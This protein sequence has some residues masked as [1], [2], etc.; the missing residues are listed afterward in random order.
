MAQP[1][2]YGFNEFFTKSPIDSVL[3]AI[4]LIWR[5]FY[6]DEYRKWIYTERAKSVGKWAYPQAEAWQAFVARALREENMAYSLD[7]SC[8]VHYLVDEEFERNRV[9]ALSSLDAPRYAGVRDAFEAAYS[10]LDSQP[11]DTKASVRSTFEAI[12][13][14]ARLIDPQSNRLNKQLVENKLKPL[15]VNLTSD[16][17]E[18]KT[19]GKLFDGIAQW[20]DGLHNYRHGQGVEHPVAPSLTLAVYIIS[21]GAAVLRWLVEIDTKQ[22]QP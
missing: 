17:T 10:Y 7:E 4:T 8:G 16:P 13:I 20:V 5:F 15:A 2:L 19:V 14:L 21:S 11:P 6:Q 9:S 3:N 12:E 22:Q 18:N 1:A